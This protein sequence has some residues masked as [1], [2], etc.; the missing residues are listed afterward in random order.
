MPCFSPRNEKSFPLQLSR[1]V[2]FREE[3]SSQTFLLYAFRVEFSF[4]IRTRTTVSTR[5]L[6][7]K[8]FSTASLS[9]VALGWS[10]A[11]SFTTV[12]VVCHF[13]ISISSLISNRISRYHVDALPGRM[14]F[15]SL[16]DSDLG[17]LDDTKRIF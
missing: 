13:S 14:A 8:H 12:T 6:F 15:A 10:N 5:Y 11:W 16:T 4:L 3:P 1:N 7:T 9:T 2:F 17:Q